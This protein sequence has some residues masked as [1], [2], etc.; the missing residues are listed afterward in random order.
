MSRLCALIL[1]R[2]RTENLVTGL[3]VLSIRSI[4]LRMTWRVMVS[5][6]VLRVIGLRMEILLL[7]SLLRVGMVIPCNVRLRMRLC[8]MSVM[9]TWVIMSRM[10][11][12]MSCEMISQV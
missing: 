7:F 2:L 11:R 4:L 3:R 5:L 12:L 1:C 6:R 8:I 10:V 9:V